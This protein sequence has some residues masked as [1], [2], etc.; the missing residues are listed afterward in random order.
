MPDTGFGSSQVLFMGI[1]LMLAG[2]AAAF[3]VSR[4]SAQF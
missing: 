1:G 2:G 4:R 3:A